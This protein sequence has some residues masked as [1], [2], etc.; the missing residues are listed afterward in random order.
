MIWG[1]ILSI[2][3]AIMI[4]LGLI[5]KIPYLKI[6][7]NW[8]Q[9]NITKKHQKL[10]TFLISLFF[11]TSIFFLALYSYSSQINEEL[12]ENITELIRDNKDLKIDL[13]KYNKSENPWGLL[14]YYFDEEDVGDYKI[15]NKILC[16]TQ[17][18]C[19]RILNLKMVRAL[20]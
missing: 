12:N 16:G 18:K 1:Y 2:I 3:S 15:N 13:E 11:I 19:K 4:I 6:P 9:E 5:E 7:F 20:L 10:A 17:R 8:I 14:E